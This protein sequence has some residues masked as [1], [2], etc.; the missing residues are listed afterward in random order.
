MN[1]L[2]KSY[3]VAAEGGGGGGGESGGFGSFGRQTGR[4]VV[5]FTEM[6]NK[7]RDGLQQRAHDAEKLI[8][9]LT[10]D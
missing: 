5:R 3:N 4:K 6:S 2:D 7:R 8:K 1:V 10:I 9:K